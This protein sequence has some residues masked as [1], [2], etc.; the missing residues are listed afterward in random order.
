VSADVE[1]ATDEEVSANL[2]R[3]ARGGTLNLVG[4][5]ANGLLAA[6]LTVIVAR[7]Y[8]RSVAGAFFAATSMFYIV[9]S[10]AELGV[11]AGLQRWIPRYLVAGRHADIRTTLRVAFR[12][13][14]VLATSVAVAVI[15]AAPAIARTRIG[16]SDPHAFAQALRLLALALPISCAY[17]LVIASTRA[18][19]TMRPNVV[20]EKLGRGLAQPV[21]VLVAAVSHA[22][23]L[24]LTVAWLLPYPVALVAALAWR[25]RILHA[26]AQGQKP[27]PAAPHHEIS[28]EFWRY[29]RPRSFAAVCQVALLRADVPLVAALR[30]PRDA[31]V[32]AAASRLLVFGQLGVQA[33]QQAIQP[34]LSRLLAQDDTR[35]TESVFRTATAW[36]MALG[37]PAYLVTASLAPLMLR[38]LF[39][40]R[41]VSGAHA[42]TIL[43]LTMLIATA[44]GPVDTLLLMAGRSWLSL[45]NNAAS[46]A[47]DVALNIVL[48]PRYGITGAA[49]AWSA[50]LVV[51]N[52]LPWIQVRRSLGFSAASPGA[53]YVALSAAVCFGVPTLVDRLTYGTRLAATV[54]TLVTGTLI[55]LICLVLARKQIHLEAF[56]GL[57]RRRAS[58]EATPRA[59]LYEAPPTPAT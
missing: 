31:A 4:A 56:A 59:V 20:I 22:G 13:V 29:T 10:I 17:D 28:R 27:L 15:I 47:V 35:S 48:I 52:G 58:G 1:T 30:S 21:C 2:V 23:L 26:R 36:L 33:V 55:Y 16:G 19:G 6:V 40:H 37:W 18:Y 14:Y 38:L 46:L 7:A 11:D 53:A 44:C 34:Q 42:L 32:Y 12:P 3:A 43:A 25:R 45:A 8:A 5:L 49:I 24:G 9:A 41:Y 54:P 51:R 50:A 57:L 39:G